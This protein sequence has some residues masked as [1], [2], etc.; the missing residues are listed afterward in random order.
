MKAKVQRRP[1]GH[2]NFT[3]I[4]LLVVIAII[5]ILAA[6]LLPALS[7]AR[8][9]AKAA[10]CTSN[11]K[12]CGLGFILYADDNDDIAPCYY[13][14]TKAYWPA[15]LIVDQYLPDTRGIYACPSCY[16]T[17]VYSTN[18]YGALPYAGLSQTA[19]IAVAHGAGAIQYS[20]NLKKLPAGMP[21]LAD[22]INSDSSA[23]NL[24]QSCYIRFA[25]NYGAHA[26]HQNIC[27]VALSDGSV[28]GA[29][30]YFFD[31]LFKNNNLTMSTGT[32]VHVAVFSPAN[33]FP[34]GAGV[35]N[36]YKILNW[37]K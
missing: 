32:E 21:L 18:C 17:G 27:N 35:V 31:E 1:L 24:T 9:R 8:E 14:S 23:G 30:P 15:T 6:M 34:A 28:T 33:D 4:E 7:A 37:W 10:Q 3:L 12:Q 19:Q 20:P 16:F 25:S 36:G 5:A 29:G 13:S 22:S 2:G 26:R 11:L